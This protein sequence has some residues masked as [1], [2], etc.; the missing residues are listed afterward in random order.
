MSKRLHKAIAK[1]SL[2]A[3]PLEACGC[4]VDGKAIPCANMAEDPKE[5]FMMDADTWLKYR[6]ETIYH[7]HPKGKN[8][9]SEHDLNVAANMELTSYVYVIESDRLEK[10]SSSQGLEIFERI[11][12]S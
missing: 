11:L 3:A 6:P 5:C 9:F 12:G 7:S 1:Q 2:K 10:W 4:V 8:G